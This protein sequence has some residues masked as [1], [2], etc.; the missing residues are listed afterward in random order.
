[1]L[2]SELFATIIVSPSEINMAV[3]PEEWLLQADF[4]LDT[5]NDLLEKG[6][7]FYAVFMC[8]LA[9]EKAL[10]GL[11]WRKLG[12]IPPKTHDLN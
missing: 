12:S 9:V 1:M 11:F 8:H 4:D 10:K 5:A 7:I 2:K 6:R 3:T